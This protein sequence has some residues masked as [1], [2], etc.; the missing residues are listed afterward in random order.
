MRGSVVGERRAVAPWGLAGGEPGAPGAN[1]L[2]GEPLPAKTEFAAA[3]GDVLEVATP[4]GGGWG[5]GRRSGSGHATSFRA[6]DLEA[7]DRH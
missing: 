7:S 4:G 5:I 1:S 2:N 6:P 3:P